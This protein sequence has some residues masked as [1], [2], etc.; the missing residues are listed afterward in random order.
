MNDHKRSDTS[1]GIQRFT[2]LIIFPHQPA[3]KKL[4]FEFMQQEQEGAIEA[5][6]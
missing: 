1:N 4:D 3:P 2:F 5:A 6:I